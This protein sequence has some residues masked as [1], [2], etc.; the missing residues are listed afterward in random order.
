MDAAELADTPE[1]AKRLGIFG[2]ERQAKV[3]AVTDGLD[4]TILMIQ[5]DPTIAR[6]WIRGGGA[7]VQGVTE[8][9]SFKPFRV[10]QANMDYGAYAIMCDGSIRF[11]KTNIP[12]ALFKAMVTYKAG[13]DTA[14][15]DEW[16]PKVELTSRLRTGGAGR[17]GGPT[18]RPS[19]SPRTGSRS[20]CGSRRRR[21]AWP[22]RRRR[23][24]T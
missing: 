15:I 21:S 10:Q 8:T 17:G 5:V 11:I 22:S 23:R 7:T 16:A 4:K 9:D 1:N 20:R 13:D 18:A 14:G 19:T 12:D 3:A 6:P 24:S 2:Y